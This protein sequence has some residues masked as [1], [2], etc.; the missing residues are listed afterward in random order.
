MGD[1]IGII[2]A[3]KVMNEIKAD[4]AGTVTQILATDGQGVEFDE[5]LIQ[6]A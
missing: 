5:P 6:L 4:K 2:E 3:M 1:T